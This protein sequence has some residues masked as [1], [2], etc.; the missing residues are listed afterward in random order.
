[1][2]ISQKKEDIDLLTKRPEQLS[3]ED[4]IKLTYWVAE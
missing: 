1:M 2:V 4:F 3:V